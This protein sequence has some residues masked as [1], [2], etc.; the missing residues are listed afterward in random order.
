MIGAESAGLAQNCAPGVVGRARGLGVHAC[1]RL[2]LGIEQPCGAV[3]AFKKGAQSKKMES[4]IV[5]GGAVRDAA[6]EM[7]A[8]LDPVEE[9]AQAARPQSHFVEVTQGEPGGVDALPHLGRNHR[10]QG[11]CVFARRPHAEFDAARALDVDREETSHVGFVQVVPALSELGRITQ[12]GQGV[13][14]FTLGR[15]ARQVQQ[16]VAVANIKHAGEVF[17]AFHVAS[18][19]VQIVGGSAEHHYSRRPIMGAAPRCPWFHHLAMN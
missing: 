9:L 1:Q 19:P 5:Q 10:A 15:R 14:P 6:K 16:S 18:G 8:I 2:V 3:R 4:I 17:R 7:R 12:A 13:S 11:T